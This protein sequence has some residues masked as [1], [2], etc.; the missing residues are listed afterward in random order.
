MLRRVMRGK[1]KKSYFVK[2]NFV[3]KHL[4]LSWFWAVEFLVGYCSSFSTAFKC[5]ICPGWLGHPFVNCSGKGPKSQIWV[6]AVGAWEADWR[7]CLEGNGAFQ[8]LLHKSS[9][10]NTAPH[11]TSAVPG[12]TNQP[13]LNFL[14][15]QWSQQRTV[16]GFWVLMHILGHSVLSLFTLCSLGGDCPI[17][18]CSK[19]QQAHGVFPNPVLPQGMSELDQQSLQL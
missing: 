4:M 10:N 2:S 19:G 1:G 9:E 11:D 3:Q 6:S 8:K 15:L 12:K 5:Q 7:L 16:S 17:S 18:C 13:L 14:D